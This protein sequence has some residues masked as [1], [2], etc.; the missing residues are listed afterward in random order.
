MIEIVMT[1]SL[2]AGTNLN[3]QKSYAYAVFGQLTGCLVKGATGNVVSQDTFV[4]DGNM[5]VLSKT[6]EV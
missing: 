6:H 3:H 1:S 4:Y 2:T 5:N